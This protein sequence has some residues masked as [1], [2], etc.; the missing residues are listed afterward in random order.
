VLFWPSSEIATLVR[1]PSA[2]LNVTSLL[3]IRSVPPDPLKPTP[4]L[5]TTLVAAINGGNL[6]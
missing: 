2:V 3:D 6:L 5:V 4:L 1:D